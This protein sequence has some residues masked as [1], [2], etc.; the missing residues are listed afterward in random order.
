VISDHRRSVVTATEPVCSAMI[1]HT[2]S[3]N[4]RAE[5][6]RFH[7]QAADCKRLLHP[8]LLDKV[9][10][11]VR[12]PDLYLAGRHPDRECSWCLV[13]VFDSTEGAPGLRIYDGAETTTA[14]LPIGLGFFSSHGLVC[15]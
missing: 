2:A 14:A 5:A 9:Q 6:L 1:R 3:P 8:E 10:I 15:Y 7:A 4:D 12:Q 13:V 11:Q